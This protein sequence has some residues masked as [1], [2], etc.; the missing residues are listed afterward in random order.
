MVKCLELEN[1]SV[2][3]GYPGA[4]ICPFYDYLYKSSIKHI[5]V[6]QEQNGGHSAN[7]YAR[8]TG[9]PAVCIATS[10]PGATNLITAIA[11]AYADSVPLVVI[12]G[13]VSTDQI[14]RDVFQEADITGSAEPFVKHS[15][16]V[17]NAD[18]IPE[19]FKKAFHIAGTG[20][21]GPVLIDVPFDIQ[22]T[23]IDF[24]Y[25]ESVEIPSYK[26]TIKGNTLQIKRVAEAIEAAEK[27]LICAGG[28][29][30]SSYATNEL[31]DFADKHDIPVVTTMMGIG[32]IR[33]DSRLHFGMIGMHGIPLANRAVLDCDLLILIGARV[34]DRAVTS[35]SFLAET[36]KIVHIDIDPAE[37]GKNIE[38]D[39][40][41]VGDAKIILGQLSEMMKP[42]KYTEW[43]NELISRKKTPEFEKKNGYINP[44]EFMYKFSEKA[45]ENTIVSADVGQNQIWTANYFT[46]KKGRFIT[47][48]GMGTMGYSVPAAV[49]AKLASP[50][51]EVVAICGDGS[52]QMQFMELATIMQ[53]RIPI[54]IIVM[55]NNRLG[56]V[57]E[58]QTRLYEDRQIAVH[59]DGSP[60][61]I[62]LAEA[63]SIPSLRVAD[64]SEIDSALDK[65]F[66]SE[67]AFLIECMVSPDESTL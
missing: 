17:K 18:E 2:V 1:I 21:K 42:V 33:S 5:L 48:G 26:P 28:G 22:K 31:Y 47:S 49:G 59:L 7:G 53:N 35:P 23:M 13:Q 11:T 50:D 58:V 16:L 63:Y 54:K 41:L 15:F 64:S 34:G 37:I 38:T 56:M 45:P 12:T 29:V 57:R 52:F 8:I 25:P 60:D 30:F 66:S 55:T 32:T 9:K 3:F 14:G 27:P 10:G 24:S 36:T 61:F 43:L 19:I 51:S 6:R 62:K 20:R 46:V 67:T 65:M 40:P 39:I 44:K 4:A